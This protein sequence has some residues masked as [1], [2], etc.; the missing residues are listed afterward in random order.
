VNGEGGRKLISFNNAIIAGESMSLPFI[1]HRNACV[2]DSTWALVLS[3]NCRH[4]LTLDA[5]IIGIEMKADIGAAHSDA[6]MPHGSNTNLNSPKQLN[7]PKEEARPS[8]MMCWLERAF[9]GR[10]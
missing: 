4:I 10:P 5:G 7:L 1:Q 9:Q 8:T 2:I 6:A 3:E